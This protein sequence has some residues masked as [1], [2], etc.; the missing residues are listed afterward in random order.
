MV[1]GAGGLVFTLDMT[2]TAV[3]IIAQNFIQLNS[4]MDPGNVTNNYP[5]SWSVYM[6]SYST[7]YAPFMVCSMLE[8]QKEELLSR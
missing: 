4:W 3:G 8:F 1:L 6:W 5:E 2:T 7:V